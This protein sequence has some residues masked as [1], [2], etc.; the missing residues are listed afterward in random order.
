MNKSF[1]PVLDNIQPRENSYDKTVEEGHSG[2]KYC[3][4]QVSLEI[5]L[6]SVQSL[7]CNS[8][9]STL[10]DRIRTEPTSI[11]Y[12]KS[13]L[14]IQVDLN[15]KDVFTLPRKTRLGLRCETSNTKFQIAIIFLNSKLLKMRLV[16]SPCYSLC[17]EENET[18]LHI[19]LQ[20]QVT[21]QYW[22]NL[23]EW[24][25]RCFTLLDLTPESALMRFINNINNDKFF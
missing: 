10:V 19:F 5:E 14:N 7:T 9:Y 2:T 4:L 25:R 16:N 22:K 15:W 17:K 21:K 11:R 6:L 13:H 24:I 1:L 23:H 20:C 8:I 12:F 3:N 18:P